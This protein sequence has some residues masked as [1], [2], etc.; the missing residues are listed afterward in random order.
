MCSSDLNDCLPSTIIVDDDTKQLVVELNVQDMTTINISGL[1]L[2][3]P[4]LPVTATSDAPAMI[5]YTSGSSGM[6]KGIILKHGGLRN[7]IEPAAQLYDLGSEIVLQQSSSSFDMS[8][9]QIF[10]AL[11]FGGSMHILSRRLRGDAHAITELIASES[12]TFTCATPS[13]YF[14]WL[15][16][17]KQD[18]LRNSQ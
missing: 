6:P 7:W 8:F 15:K 13:E 1:Q 18:L 9:T 2:G 5:L 12:I 11:S 4:P 16:Y 17:G 14:S 10:T 3:K